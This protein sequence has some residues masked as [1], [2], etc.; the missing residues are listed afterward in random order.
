MLL[1]NFEL[2]R[3]A[4]VANVLGAQAASKLFKH[5]LFM[6]GFQR[7]PNGVIFYA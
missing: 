6:S 5:T 4:V 2:K 1:T 7:Q 3:A